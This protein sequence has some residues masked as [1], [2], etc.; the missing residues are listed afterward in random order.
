MPEL[1]KRP[2]AY[3]MCNKFSKI[4]KSFHDAEAFVHFLE[5]K[6]TDEKTGQINCGCSDN[7]RD[8]LYEFFGINYY[9]LE[10]ERVEMLLKARGEKNVIQQ[11]D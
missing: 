11:A 2:E 9:Q 3:P 5:Q 8:L 10:R 7:L 4:S 6:C 1:A